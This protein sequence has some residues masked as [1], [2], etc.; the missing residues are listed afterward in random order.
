V[1]NSIIPPLDVQ[2]SISNNS[3]LVGD[4][5]VVKW[6]IGKAA[7]LKLVILLNALLLVVCF[8]VGFPKPL[9]DQSAVKL[10]LL[11]ALVAVIILVLGVPLVGETDVLVHPLLVVP[12]VAYQSISPVTPFSIC[13]VDVLV[14][15]VL[16]AYEPYPAL[17]KVHAVLIPGLAGLP[18]DKLVF[19]AFPDST[20]IS[21]PS[22][23]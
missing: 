18:L 14:A 12:A 11:T 19:E 16:V 7:Y 22:A 8:V 9:D 21:D 20:L 2:S 5:S 3:E 10:K 1:L 13:E 23:N 17:S 4:K 15:L 6:F